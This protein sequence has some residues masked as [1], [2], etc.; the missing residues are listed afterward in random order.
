V[1]QA[2]YAVFASES[3]HWTDWFRTDLGGRLDVFLFDID[4]GLAANSGTG[5]ASIASPK[6]TMVFGAWAKT[7]YFLNAGYGFHSKDAR[8]TTITVDPNDG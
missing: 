2:S 4:S 3:V 1:K 8:G 6:L 7:G 5:N